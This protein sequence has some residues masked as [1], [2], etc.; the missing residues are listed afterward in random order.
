MIVLSDLHIGAVRSAGTSPASS[1][2]LRDHL[3]SS[4]K[5]LLNKADEDVILNGDIFDSS[6]VSMT[7]LL[8]TYNAVLSWLTKGFNLTIVVGNHDL[9][10]DTSK[11][12]SLQFMAALLA[13]E[14]NVTYVSGS[15]RLNSEIYI[16]SHVTNQDLFDLELSKVPTC[17]YLLLHCN[18]DN[19]FSK[20]LDNSLNLSEQQALDCKAEYIVLGHEHHTRKALGGKVFIPGNQIASSIADC[21]GGHDKYMTH[22]GYKPELVKVWDSAANYE[23]ID[24]RNPAP[25]TAQFIRFVGHA[26]PEEAAD[27]ADVIARYRRTSEAFVVAN[28]VRVTEDEE[29]KELALQSLEEINKF[30]VMEA[31]KEYLTEEELKIVESLNA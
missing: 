24:W 13:K 19:P 28:A 16:I 20:H 12:S 30:N 9:Y 26:K 17:K 31:L 21:I 3:L 27:M 7:D 29:G 14:P 11:L 18:Y 8:E 2:A 1:K 25:S 23:E 22:L 6:N 15:Y 4:F 10:T 5:D